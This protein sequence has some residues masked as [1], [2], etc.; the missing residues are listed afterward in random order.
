MLP[1]LSTL[2]ADPL[3]ARPT[4]AIPARSSV[5][6]ISI[7]KTAAADTKSARAT[8]IAAGTLHSVD[9]SGSDIFQV[10]AVACVPAECPTGVGAHRIARGDAGRSPDERLSHTGQLLYDRLYEQGA[11]ESRPEHR[12]GRRL[13]GVFYALSDAN[14]TEWRNDVGASNDGL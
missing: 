14:G 11:A 1:L 7:E 13:C 2:Q 4:K 12:S 5:A 8:A 9:R 3:S 6:R 10:R